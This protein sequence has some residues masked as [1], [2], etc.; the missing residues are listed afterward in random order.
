MVKKNI[1]PKVPLEKVLLADTPFKRVAIYKIGPLS[2]TG[3]RFILTL[4]GYA[5]RYAEAVPLRKIDAETVAEALVDICSRLGISE[6]ALSDQGTQYMS[7]CMREV[8]RLLLLRHQAEG[9]D[10]Y[11]QCGQMARWR[12]LSRPKTCLRRLCSEQPRQWHRYINP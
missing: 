1:L 7:D 4:V 6:E 11:H 2:E 8:C 3:H 10:T 9:D 5:T 12:G